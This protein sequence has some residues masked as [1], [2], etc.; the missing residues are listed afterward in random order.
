[1]SSGIKIIGTITD[2]ASGSNKTLNI[3]NEAIGSVAANASGPLGEFRS[4][5]PTSQRRVYALVENVGSADAYW[6]RAADIPDPPTETA[7]ATP[8]KIAAGATVEID[9]FDL[10]TWNLVLRLIDGADVLVTVGYRGEGW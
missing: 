4:A 10:R 2:T 1:M 3:A 8:L 6:T 7:A 5:S 9:D